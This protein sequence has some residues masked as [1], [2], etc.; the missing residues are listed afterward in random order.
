[1]ERY[2][3]MR[4]RSSKLPG[5]AGE[6]ALDADAVPKCDA[7][8][9]FSRCGLRLRVV[10]SSVIVL[11]AVDCDMEIVG[12]ALPRTDRGVIAG[13]EEFLI[14]T[15]GGEILVALDNDSGA[16]FRDDSSAPGC[17]GHFVRL[18]PGKTAFHQ[19]IAGP[20]SVSRELDARAAES[21]QK[22]VRSGRKICA[23]KQRPRS[24]VSL[25]EMA[26]GVSC[27]PPSQWRKKQ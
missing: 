19:N 4:S 11:H 16:A 8:L 15:F 22:S 20:M 1:M 27:N 21:A 18:R 17:L 12:S 14:D 2:S 3:R 13:L 10:P 6:S 23:S 5:C 7:V 24:K 9:D 25:G 26:T